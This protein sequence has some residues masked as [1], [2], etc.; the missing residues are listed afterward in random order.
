[1]TDSIDARTKRTRHLLMAGVI[2]GPLFIS[3]VLIQLATTPGFDLGRHPISLLSLSANGW[4][5]IT[6]FVVGGLLA[7]AFA[8]GARRVLSGRGSTWGPRL[9]A[10]YGFGLIAGGVFLAD[11][12]LGFPPGAPEGIP[13][14]FSWHGTIHAFAPPAALTALIGAVIV[15]ARSF[16]ER[17]ERG[18]VRYSALTVVTAVALVMS[19][20]LDGGSF[21]LALATAVGWAWVA[22]LAA[23]LLTGL[24]ETVESTASWVESSSP[25]TR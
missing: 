15:F 8:V 13:S 18:W 22:A 11:P 16:S 20:G 24:D 12:G 7:I 5:Q 4:I 6:N 19:M 17:G 10:L 23:R 2:A 3:V 21:R 9:L 25:A 14:T 1:M